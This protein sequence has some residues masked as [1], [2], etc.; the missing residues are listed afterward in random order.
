MLVIRIQEVHQ[1]EATID[2]ELD[3]V[4]KKGILV[5]LYISS[6][7]VS[8]INSKPEEICYIHLSEIF[9]SHERATAHKSLSIKI[10]QLQIDN[11]L[12]KDDTDLVLFKERGKKSSFLN[13]YTCLVN[14]EGMEHLLHFRDFKISIHPMILLL[15]GSFCD[16]LFSFYKECQQLFKLTRPKKNLDSV[17][18]DVTQK[19]KKGEATQTIF[20]ENFYIDHFRI[21]FSFSSSPAL[22]NQTSMNA[23]LKFLLALLINLKQVKLSFT[24]LILDQNQKSLASFQNQII[25]HYRAQCLKSTQL[26]QIITSLGIIGTLNETLYNFKNAFSSIIFMGGHENLFQGIVTGSSNFVRYSLFAVSNALTDIIQGTM[27]ALNSLSAITSPKLARD[28]I[29][30]A[31]VEAEREFVYNVNSMIG[32]L[33]AQNK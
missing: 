20:F 15:D 25:K 9:I 22:L 21:N 3:L 4:E 31:E 32:L 1:A 28:E 18:K 27:N 24:P 33:D 30:L 8:L 29:M 23:S 17:P 26:I 5:N 11:Q 19:L 16:S 13:F 7:G 14:N 6:L 10:D 2:Q 12:T